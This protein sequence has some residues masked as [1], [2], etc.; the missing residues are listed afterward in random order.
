M[1]IDQS[2]S[3][4]DCARSHYHAANL[5]FRHQ[6]GDASFGEASFDLV[7]CFEVLEHVED[8]Q[9]LAS[10]LAH[11]TSR[12]LLVSFP[13]GRMRDFEVN[14][15]HLRNFRPGDFEAFMERIGL[16]S[17]EVLYAGFP[18]YSPIFRDFCNL[19]NSA[20]N[21]MTKGHNSFWTRRLGDLI[22]FSFRFL[23][24]R[25]RGGDQFCGLFERAGARE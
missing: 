20:G 11:A 25:R 5:E 18:F 16:R 3:G 22:F 6:P 24:T 10:R 19:T 4:I 12:Y 8:W 15:G 21:A 13:T 2:G 9:A 23:S 17:V 7:T 14:I 1:G